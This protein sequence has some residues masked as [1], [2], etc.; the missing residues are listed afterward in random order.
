MRLSGCASSTVTAAV[1]CS[2]PAAS[3]PR[4]S[5]RSQQLSTRSW[6]P[7]VV[8]TRALPASATQP[9]GRRSQDADI[10]R[11]SVHDAV[12]HKPGEITTNSGDPYKVFTYFSRKWHDREKRPAADPT[13]SFVST[14]SAVTAAVDAVQASV[15]T[16][17]EL[18]VDAPEAEIPP[19]GTE[20]ARELLE[21][22]CAADIYRYDDRRDYPADDCTSRLSA[23]FAHGTIGVR[24][25]YARTERA[26]AAAETEAEQD[27]VEEFQDQ[28]AWR[29]FYTQVLW[30]RPDVVTENYKEYENPI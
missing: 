18:G 7:G 16:R 26:K 17:S 30:D 4:L 11:E 27:S 1:T 15:P 25:V 3:P 23:H 21:S 14:G 2:S 24:E 6:S 28:M 8:I 5:L 20:T 22:F 13:A 29:E 12:H 9:F 19:A 10:D